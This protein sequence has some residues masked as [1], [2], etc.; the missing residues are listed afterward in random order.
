MG[1]YM[2][3]LDRNHPSFKIGY[4]PDSISI[5]DGLVESIKERLSPK[6]LKLQDPREIHKEL[7][8]LVTRH[9][10]VTAP[11]EFHRDRSKYQT[12]WSRS[13][14]INLKSQYEKEN[15]IVYDRVIFS[16]WDIRYTGPLNFEQYPKDILVLPSAYT[17][18]HLCDFWAIGPSHLIDIYARSLDTLDL[19]KTTPG[20]HTNP[21]E[22]TAWH[23]EYYKVPYLIADIPIFLQ[24]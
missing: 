19:V 7:D 17:Y 18:G 20:F 6:I 8:E 14:C 13:A 12:F 2:H 11:W 22:W 1:F 24:R 5:P 16:R 15:D 3:V 4:N 9:E 21:H 23:L 10:D